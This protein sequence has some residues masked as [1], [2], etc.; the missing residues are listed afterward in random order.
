MSDHFFLIHCVWYDWCGNCNSEGGN[1]RPTAHLSASIYWYSTS[2]S[3]RVGSFVPLLWGASFI[4]LTTTGTMFGL[5]N[6]TGGSVDRQH[7]LSLSQ[8]QLAVTPPQGALKLEFQFTGTNYMSM[9]AKSSDLED[10]T[11]GD[12]LQMGNAD[13]PSQSAKDLRELGHWALLPSF[14]SPSWYPARRLPSNCPDSR[15]CLEIHA[16]LTGEL[17]AVPPLSHAWMAPLM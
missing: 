4:L 13:V 8:S 3:S 5:V 7:A 1:C 10:R 6:L 12:N 15:H 17:G 9:A 14:H 2:T 11:S 16:T